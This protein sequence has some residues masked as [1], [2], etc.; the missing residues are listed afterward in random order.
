M[1]SAPLPSLLTSHCVKRLPQRNA[2]IAAG[3][4]FIGIHLKMGFLEF[5]FRSAQQ[6]SIGKAAAGEDDLR[7]AEMAC[8]L[9]NHL[10]QGFMKSQGFLFY[11]IMTF[12]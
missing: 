10:H 11:C 8:T 12:Q 4:F 7:Q 1:N 5:F 3:N 6:Q 2:A 9:M